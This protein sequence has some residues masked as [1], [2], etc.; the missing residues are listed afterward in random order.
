MKEFLDVRGIHTSYDGKTD[1]LTDIS[2]QVNKGEFVGII[3]PS[4]GG[5]STLLKSMN[6]LV[7]PRKGQVLF[8]GKDLCGLSKKELQKAR[9]NMGFIFQEYNLI[10]E[11]SVVENV[12][13]GNIYEDATWKVLLK[14]YSKEDYEKALKNLSLVGLS[15]K[16]F[17][18]ARDLSGGEKQ[19]VAIARTLL[20]SPDIILADEPVSS[21]DMAAVQT[22]MKYFKKVN[23]ELRIP[24]LMNL[25]D[26]DLAREYCH[27]LIGIRGGKKVFDVKE[28]EL[29]EELLRQLYN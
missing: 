17:S 23:E 2:L 13:L 8:E 15:D 25:H 4:G 20:Q 9:S 19:R 3:G 12:L 21:L 1:V 7:P 27:R 18:Y 6:L 5:K 29:H 24:I 10:E 16:A 28:N 11:S 22:V 26:V 14:L